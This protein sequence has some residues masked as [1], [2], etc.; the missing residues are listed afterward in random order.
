MPTVK[1]PNFAKCERRFYVANRNKHNIS[2]MQPE[3]GMIAITTYKEID[4]ITLITKIYDDRT[5]EGTIKC[6]K[7]S[8]EII[9]DL[10]VDD[11][12]IVPFDVIYGLVDSE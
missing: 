2:T 5:C 8:E 9:D 4:V 11:H 6:F 10:A 1:K 12:V 3:V 7:P